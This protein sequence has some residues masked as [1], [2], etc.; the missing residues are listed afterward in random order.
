MSILNRNVGGKTLGVGSRFYIWIGEKNVKATA[1]KLQGATIYFKF[2]R[3]KE[4]LKE[5]R[6]LQGSNISRAQ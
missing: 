6:N 5:F 4:K 3:E 1:F 2:M